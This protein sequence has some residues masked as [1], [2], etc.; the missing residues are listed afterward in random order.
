[1]SRFNRLL[2][3]IR[4]S[5]QQIALALQ[6]LTVMSAEL[7][8]AFRAISINQVRDLTCEGCKHLFE[9]NQIP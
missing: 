6:G 7:E 2:S 4:T 9:R 8:S 3:A 1:M 5:L